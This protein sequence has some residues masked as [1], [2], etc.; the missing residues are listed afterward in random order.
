MRDDPV[1]VAN[2][3]CI[4]IKTADNGFVLSYK[5]PV[6]V[7]QN[8]ENDGWQDPYRSRVYNTPEALAADLTKLLPLM[9]QHSAERNEAQDYA[10]E[11]NK[12]FAEQD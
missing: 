11:L 3:D 9:K 5:D 2:M 6:I 1:L 8:A 10:A 4:E 7:K 12:A